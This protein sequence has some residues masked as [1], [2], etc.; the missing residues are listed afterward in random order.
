[1]L[2]M[3]KVLISG[4]FLVALLA[5][6]LSGCSQETSQSP[7]GASVSD[8]GSAALNNPAQPL[9]NGVESTKP[10]IIPL[11]TLSPQEIAINSLTVA[12]KLST[13]KFDMDLN[14]RFDLGDGDQSHNMSIQET[15]TGEVNIP[16]KEMLLLMDLNMNI[17]D[18]SMQNMA[19]D[20]YLTSGWIYMKA[21]MPGAGAGWIKMK[22]TDE[23]WTQQ[24]RMTSM[25]EFLKSPLNVE[26]L[27]SENIRGIDCYVLSITPDMKSIYEWMAG[28]TFAGQSGM[29]PANLNMSPSTGDFKIKEWISKTDYLVTRQQIGIKFNVSKGSTTTAPSGTQNKIAM[30]MSA[31]LDY[32][33][34]GKPVVIQLPPEALNAQE[35][36]PGTP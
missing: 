2:I 18:Q 19:A 28:Q 7:S 20:M 31:L 34:Y 11:K 21:D 6:L 22:L 36:S 3:K 15:A 16:G 35:M 1:M 12:E 32:Y 17:P 14:L 13:M 9:S 23:L 25:T 33:D 30:D 5:V 10:A 4:V 26:Q 8:S 24:S 27:G 29:D